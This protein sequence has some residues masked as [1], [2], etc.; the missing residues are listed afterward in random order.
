MTSGVRS[1][2]QYT[3]TGVW[4]VVPSQI[5]RCLDDPDRTLLYDDDRGS[6]FQQHFVRNGAVVGGWACDFAGIGEVEGGRVVRSSV[7]RPATVLPY[8]LSRCPSCLTHEI[9]ETTDTCTNPDC[10]SHERVVVDHRDRQGR[11]LR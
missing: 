4:G 10:V 9:D 5:R 2:Y 1:V 6:W 3:V 8:S 11:R 7:K